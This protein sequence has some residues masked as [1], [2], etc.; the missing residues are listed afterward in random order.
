[1][2]DIESDI[3]S[4]CD[5]HKKDSTFYAKVQVADSDRSTRQTGSN[6]AKLAKKVIPGQSI[7]SEANVVPTSSQGKM[8]DTKA[9]L[10]ELKECFKDVTKQHR[11]DNILTLNE[12]PFFGIPPSED[13]KKWIIPLD[14]CISFLDTI[15]K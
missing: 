14:D 10:L 8:S 4:D 2:S 7:A 1:M 3:G 6:L 5:D 12:L 13:T 9:I 15:E 11:H